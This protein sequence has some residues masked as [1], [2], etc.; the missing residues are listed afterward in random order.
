MKGEIHALQWSDIKDGYLSV[1]KS[2]TQKLSGED[3]ITPPKN[4]SSVRTLQLPIPLIEILEQH[5]LRCKSYEGFTDE[6][7]VCGI[8]KSLR[9]TTIENKNFK[10]S[11]AAGIKKFVFMILDI[12]MR[13]YLLMKE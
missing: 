6:A 13:V 7:Y 12:H 1:T 5:Y 8:T 9:D 3:R 2:I 10:Y 11:K 4:R